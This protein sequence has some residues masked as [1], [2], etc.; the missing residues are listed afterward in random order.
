MQQPGN[1]ASLSFPQNLSGPLEMVAQQA[2]RAIRVSLE[3]RHLGQRA[4][5]RVTQGIDSVE[6]VG[7][8]VDLSHLAPAP[9]LTDVGQESISRRV[10]D[11]R[12][13]RVNPVGKPGPAAA[14]QPVQRLGQGS[15]VG[16][17]D[18]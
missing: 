4:N 17:V 13:G 16:E 3:Q 11:S 10:K 15:G 7:P 18:W 5:R 2:R 14:V 12:S 8:L 1:V 9:Q 6:L